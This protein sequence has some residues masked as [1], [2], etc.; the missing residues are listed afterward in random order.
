MEGLGTDLYPDLDIRS[1]AKPI[2]TEWVKAQMNP[3][4]N[5]KELGQKIP[6]LLLG[7]QDLPMLMIDS[8]NGLKNQ[9]AWHSKQLHELQMM[10]LEVEHQQKRSRMFGSIMAILLSIA[11][12]APWY[13]SIVLIVIASV[14]AVLA[15]CKVKPHIQIKKRAQALFF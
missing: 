15:G 1:L 8:L 10:R 14:L 6:D 13:I 2:L 4:K 9:S 5:L 11:I 7:A 12:I 3:Q